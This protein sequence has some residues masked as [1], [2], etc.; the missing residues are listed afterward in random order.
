MR[1]DRWDIFFFVIWGCCAFAVGY[2]VSCFRQKKRQPLFTVR[3]AALLVFCCY[4]AALLYLTGMLEMIRYP[5]TIKLKNVF[6]G[7]DL[8]LFSG[9]VFHPILQNFLLFL[10]LGFFVPSV[11][12]KVRWNLLRALL[13]G[14]CVS[15]T[16]ELLQGLIGRLQEADDLAVNTAGA[17]AG[18]LVWAALF[19]REWKLWQRILVLILTAGASFAG[20]YGIRALCAIK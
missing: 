8:T 2:A 1:I 10:P 15:C 6:T 20:L 13:L 9:H 3:N 19:R 14:F 16:I 17:A 4:G 11:T 18:Y 5:G 7:F 12:P